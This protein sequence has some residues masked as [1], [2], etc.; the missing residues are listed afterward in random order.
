M[1][2]DICDFRF[3]ICDLSPGARAFVS[4][5]VPESESARTQPFTLGVGSLRF[6]NFHTRDEWN[7]Q[8]IEAVVLR[9][10]NDHGPSRGSQNRK[11]RMAH[12]KRLVARKVNGERSKWRC[13]E[14]GPQLIGTHIVVMFAMVSGAIQAR[15]ANLE[16]QIPWAT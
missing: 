4:A 1:N 6:V 12:G 3:A 11:L 7:L 9:M 15:S 5:A 8:E 2:K 10:Q 16:L 14:K 13:S